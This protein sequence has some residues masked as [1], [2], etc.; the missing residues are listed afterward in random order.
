MAWRTETYTG[1]GRALSAT[2]EVARPERL[3]A[4]AGLEPAPARGKRRSYGDACLN[5]AGRIVD[6]TRLNRILGF[7]EDTGLLH[8]EAGARL[9]ELTQLFAPRGWLPPVMPGTGFATVGGAIAMDVHGKNHHGAGSFGQHV[10]EITLMRGGKTVKEKAGSKAFKATVGGLGQTGVITSAK[11]TMKPIQGDAMVVRERRME[12]WEEFIGE[13]DTTEATYCVGWIDAIATGSKLGRGILEEAEI[14]TGFVKAAGKSKTVPFDAPRFALSSPI[15]RAFN[16]AYFR[17]V[18]VTGRT[19][20]RSFQDFF[21][22]LD[23]LHDWNRL[24]GK[25]G[26]HQFQCV[27][28]LGAARALRAMLADIASSGL[29]SPLAVLK[30]MGPGNAGMMSFPMEGYTLA[31]DFPA[32]DKAESLIARLEDMAADAGGRIYLA[33]DSLATAATID[34]MYPDRAAWAAQVQKADPEEAMATDIIRRLELR[35]MT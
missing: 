24:Y 3:S 15:V 21:F 2:G 4:L 28:P 8:V 11:F 16:A 31:V 22:P 19:V 10:T 34:K 32:K 17:R 26:F 7:D 14:G 20:A 35:R 27:V 33:K 13:L 5:D 12:G 29:A 23:K 9:G 6:L 18:P 25:G 30:R 1:W